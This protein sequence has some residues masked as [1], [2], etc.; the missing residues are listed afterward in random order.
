MRTFAGVFR[1]N[2]KKPGNFSTPPTKMM[3]LMRFVFQG[4]SLMRE[5]SDSQLYDSILKIM[6]VKAT[7]NTMHGRNSWKT[8]GDSKHQARMTEF[9]HWVP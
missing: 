6:I 5:K 4:V 1:L 3:R 8:S 2:I 9:R 7:I